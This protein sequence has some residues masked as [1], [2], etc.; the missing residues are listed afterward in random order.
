M[1]LGESGVLMAVPE[2]TVTPV[3]PA[4]EAVVEVE[5]VVNLYLHET[6]SAPVELK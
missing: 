2:V 5:E 6:I 4:K 3:I 1:I